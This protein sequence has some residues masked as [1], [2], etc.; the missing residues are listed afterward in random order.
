[1]REG[2]E[3]YAAIVGK[4]SARSGEERTLDQEGLMRSEERRV[5]RIAANN[6]GNDRAHQVTDECGARH[7]SFLWRIF[8]GKG[9]RLAAGIL[10]PL[11]HV[12]VGGWI[13]RLFD[14]IFVEFV[15]HRNRLAR[16]STGYCS[17]ELTGPRLECRRGACGSRVRRTNEACAW[18]TGAGRSDGMAVT[19]WWNECEEN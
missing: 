8:V 16:P 13:R 17:L 11:P 19:K 6:Q 4:V 10:L 2:R 9:Q 14:D 3:T 18:G 15:R 12:D 1:M 5:I 7:D